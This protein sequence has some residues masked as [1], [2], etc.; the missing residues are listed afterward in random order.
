ML[1]RSHFFFKQFL[2]W[3]LR[4]PT[5]YS[6]AGCGD[7]TSP[8]RVINS[9]LQPFFWPFGPGVVLSH[10][11]VV[12]NPFEGGGGYGPSPC[13]PGTR[14]AEDRLLYVYVSVCVL[15]GT[16]RQVVGAGDELPFGCGMYDQAGYKFA[17]VVEA[18]HVQPQHAVAPR[19]LLCL[20]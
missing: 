18:E 10:L 2:P 1:G 3:G 20:W 5:P 11:G 13:E 16:G 9:Y 6:C 4:I 15:Q 7:K 17:D 14:V 8:K 12:F 19:T